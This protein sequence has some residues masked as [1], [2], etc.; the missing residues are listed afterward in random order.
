VVVTGYT[1]WCQIHTRACI[2]EAFVNLPLTCIL[3]SLPRVSNGFAVD[4]MRAGKNYFTL[5]SFTSDHREAS[6]VECAC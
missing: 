6:T 5:L 1:V 2:F 3:L 4:R